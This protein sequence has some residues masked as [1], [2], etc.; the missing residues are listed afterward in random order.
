M[1]IAGISQPR[2]F[3]MSLLN[4]LNPRRDGLVF[5]LKA[6]LEFIRCHVFENRQYGFTRDLTICDLLLAMIVVLQHQIVRAYCTPEILITKRRKPIFNI[7]R[8]FKF[9][10]GF[11]LA[12]FGIVA[13]ISVLRTSK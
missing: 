12:R 13:Q 7:I 3:T 11:K 5:Q 4:Q 8:V 9:L 10:H 1:L 6:S 2:A